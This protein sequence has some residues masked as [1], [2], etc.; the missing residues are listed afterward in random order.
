MVANAGILPTGPLN[1]G[2]C[3]SI[4]VDLACD[5]SFLLV[6]LEEWDR[7]FAINVRGTFLCFKYASLQL[8]K[9]GRG[10]RL[11]GASSGTGKKGARMLGLYASTKFAIR[12]LTQSAGTCT[13]N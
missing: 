8:I 3:I 12:G 1:D 6:T 5:Y 9:Q 11:I 2:R 13:Q 4:V 7:V 10:G